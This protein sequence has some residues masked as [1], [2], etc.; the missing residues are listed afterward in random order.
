MAVIKEFVS[1]MCPIRLGSPLRVPSYA[2]GN[3]GINWA[4]ENEFRDL[5]T[6]SEQKYLEEWELTSEQG[7]ADIAEAAKMAGLGD[8]NQLL[9]EAC[10]QYVIN[11]IEKQ[12][13]TLNILDVGAGNGNTSLSI[14]KRVG[15]L[16]KPIITLIDVSPKALSEAEVKLERTGYKNGTNFFTESIRDS[17]SDLHFKEESFDI[18]ISVAA[19]HHHADLKVGLQPL[20]KLLKKKGLFII[21]DWFNSLWEHPFRVLSLLLALPNW[22]G[23]GKDIQKFIQLFPNAEIPEIEVNSLLQMANNLII[24]FWKNYGYLKKSL[25]ANFYILEGHR[26]ADHYYKELRDTGI[27]P[28]NQIDYINPYRS[29]LGV[30]SG[31][32]I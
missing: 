22:D 20:V 16:E 18:I 27:V 26:S 9:N 12:G 19:L 13:K 2:W 7:Y 17:E 30:I 3:W 14:A 8:A 25:P 29:I 31:R 10:S 32:K 15:R 24:E 11:E 4:N 28:I 5:I 6:L 1:L 23:K 21:G